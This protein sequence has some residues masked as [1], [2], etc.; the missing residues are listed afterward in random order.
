M[1]IENSSYT[2]KKMLEFCRLCAGFVRLG[3]YFIDEDGTCHHGLEE[4]PNPGSYDSIAALLNE[5]SRF[6]VAPVCQIILRRCLGKVL[7]ALTGQHA[8]G[9]IAPSC[10]TRSHPAALPEILT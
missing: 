10:R 4:G 9:A 2:F 6:V 3:G 1:V 7:W 5:D 8:A